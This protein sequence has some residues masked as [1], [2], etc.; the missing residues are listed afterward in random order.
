M[1]KWLLGSLVVSLVL[2]HIRGQ[3]Q[4]DIQAGCSTTPNDLVYIID[5]SSS[6]GAA[7]FETAK[8]W[9]I[10]IT[11][12][13]DVSL[14][15]TQV[16]VVQYSDTPRLEIPLGRH[17]DTQ[18]LL[19]DIGYIS[20]LG[21][22][23]QT[24]R[25]IKFAS[26]HVFPSSNP[27]VKAT[28]NRIAVIL[29]DGRS[30]DDVVDP[31]MDAK[32]QGIALFAV[33][34]G[35]EITNAELVSM[36]TKPSSTYVLHV[37]DYTS[38]GS[39]REAMEQ[40]LCEESVC[41]VRIPGTVNGQKGFDLMSLMG[42]VEV[43]K[44]VQGSLVSEAAYLLSPHLDVTRSTREIFPEGLPPSYVFVATLRVK[45]PAHHMKFDLWR[46]LSQDRI[47]QVAVTLNGAEKSVTFTSTSALKKEQTV[48]FND[49][50]IKRLFDTDWHQLKLL[51]KP[52]RITCYLDD[53]HVEEQLLEPVVSI[54]INGKTQVAKKVN[55]ET[56]V[57]VVLQKLRLYCDPVQSQRE[58]ACEI[59]SV[60]DDRCP[61]DRA[62][63]VEGCDCP[64]GKPG[65][66][67]LP[68]SMGF[69]GEKGREGPPGPDGKPGK[70][71]EK[72]ALGQAGRDG[73]KGEAGRPGPKGKRGL[74]GAKGD[75]GAKGP[76][77]IPGPPGPVGPGLSMWDD[78]RVE[79]S[80]ETSGQPGEAGPP[81]RPGSVGEPGLSG[82]DGLPGLA[83]QKGEKGDPGVYGMDGQNGIPGIRG[84]PGEMGPVGP[85]G[86]RGL[87][88]HQGSTG[89]KGPQGP[90]GP[91]GSP[92]AEGPSGPKGNTGQR[93]HEG[94]PG[95]P[96]SKGL[97]GH[98]GPQGPPGFR[99]P[100]GL[101][102]HK[103]ETGEPG[104]KGTQGEKGSGGL[105]G[106]P[107]KPGEPGLRGSKG[108]RGIAGDPGIR[109]P[110][111][112]KGEMGA[113][114][115][116]GPRGF[117]GQVG[118]PGQPGLPGYPGK[119]G[120]LPSEQHL[121]KICAS[122][123]QNQLPQLLQ[124]MSPSSCQ[125]CETI[126][127]PPGD[128][129]P[130]GPQ[131]STGTPGYPGRPGAQGYPGP[132]GMMGPEGAKGEVGSMGMKGAKGEG[133]IGLQGPPGPPGIQGP[134]G[135]AGEGY[136]GPPG[137]TGKHGSPGIPGKRGPPGAPGICDP[138]S[139]YQG[140]GL[141]DNHFTK[142]PN[143]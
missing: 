1:R 42:I 12:G 107:A 62:A 141:P 101:N 137:P 108:E 57:P 8:R 45:S 69:R 127:G 104:I 143:F 50:G 66:P 13:F 14:R 113:M 120:K 60:G 58:G 118:L 133:D 138:S 117:P 17:Q 123:L 119:P 70:P 72:G 85:Q 32:A 23:T 46:V 82:K 84:P 134:R 126:K 21:G 36:A 86:E 20:Y 83:G 30:Q 37:E 114:G 116:A 94:L 88:G 91:V 98:P 68:G 77:G 54:Y 81:G 135:D 110:D 106:V 79:E 55:I 33:G 109:G 140:Y 67:G 11:S 95:P 52:K 102:G 6:L 18:E 90:P 132:P 2:M 5:G 97:D 71:G 103:G 131:G 29:T 34:V 44:K 99:G 53:T 75:M 59:Y 115:P 56:T 28:R 22:R 64:G 130:P 105:P 121:M 47:K 25:A 51:V 10:N 15:H 125:K 65:Q 124:V 122:V 87:P 7:D 31:A 128:L 129:G 80:K 19:R 38:I 63:A 4:K 92:G 93:G 76:P 136:A 49:R 139:C 3:N 73:E 16:A 48:I 61:A 43:A 40:K 27:T 112:K 35:N 9:L 26:H 111:G 24:G 100:T 142:G 89:P 96:G 41:P 78:S 74:T 39:I